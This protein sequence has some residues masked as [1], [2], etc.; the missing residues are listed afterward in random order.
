MTGVLAKLH[1][2][3]RV[4]DL[5]VQRWQHAETQQGS[6]FEHHVTYFR[7]L[8]DVAPELADVMRASAEYAWDE[9]MKEDA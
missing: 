6:L 9:L 2:A 8:Y 7:D 4:A 1:H 5:A 3:V